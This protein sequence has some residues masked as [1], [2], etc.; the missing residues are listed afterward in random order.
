[1]RRR[2]FLKVVASSTAGW[3]L[4]VGAQQTGKL[5]IIGFLGSGA[6]TWTPWTT[7]FVQ[8][9]R[10]LGWIEGR[11]VAIEYRWSEGKPER[12][13]AIA[14]EFVHLKV[15]VVVSYGTAIPALKHATSTIPIVFAIAIDPVG[16]GFITNLARPGGNVTGLSIQGT[17]VAGKQLE[18]LREVI[19]DLRRLAILGNVALTL[20]ARLPSIFGTRDYLKAGGLMAYG[21]NFPD[22]FRRAAEYVDKILRGSKILRQPKQ[23]ALQSRNR[24]YC[25]PTR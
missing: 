16:S 15:D 2:D 7:A 13:A 12:D 19:P 24:S 4:G 1:M 21:P 17:D 8:R 23:S 3:P 6:E 18:I 25:A 10:E 5:P 11:T 22:L 20:G 9:I 14:A